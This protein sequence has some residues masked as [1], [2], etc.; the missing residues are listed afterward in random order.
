MTIKYYL[1]GPMTGYPQFNFPLFHEAADKLRGMGFDI[2]SPAETDTPAVQKAAMASTTGALDAQG[3]IA[4]ETWGE[5]LA[6]DVIIVA[7]QVDGIVFLPGWPKSK[8]ARLEAFV[9]IL[10]GKTQFFDYYEGKVYTTN[11]NRIKDILA[12]ELT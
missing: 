4:G 3:K 6:K 10:A 12:G 9:A 5:I 2:I 1:A 11:P 7:D 8:G